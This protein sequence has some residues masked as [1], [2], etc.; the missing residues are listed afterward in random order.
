MRNLI[1]QAPLRLTADEVDGEIYFIDGSVDRAKEINIVITRDPFW[2]NNQL[3]Y[4]LDI[5][6]LKTTPIASVHFGVMYK[7]DRM[8]GVAYVRTSRS[9]TRDEERS[10]VGGITGQWS[11][12][13]GESFE[14]VE[15]KGA[16]PYNEYYASF[17]NMDADWELEKVADFE[18]PQ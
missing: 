10:L 8:W 9:L 4:V 15:I 7:D 14:Q 13:W 1:Y 2:A 12:G 17:W 16:R 11:D 3:E 6:D 5:E 18:Y